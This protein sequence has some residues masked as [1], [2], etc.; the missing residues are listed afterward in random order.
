MRPPRTSALSLALIHPSAWNRD[1]QKFAF[2]GFCELRQEFIADSSLLARVFVGW[3]YLLSNSR[4]LLE[5][6]DGFP[7]AHPFLLPLLTRV[8]E[9]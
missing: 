5:L 4:S 2:W 8:H 6:L 3:V 1:S 9:R 7:V